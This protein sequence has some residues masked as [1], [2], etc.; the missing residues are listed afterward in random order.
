MR[1]VRICLVDNYSNVL[2]NFLNYLNFLKVENIKVGN[3]LPYLPYIRT[4]E[5]VLSNV[6]E[7][8]IIE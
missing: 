6:Y 3:P 4:V 7:K 5:H 2:S 8:P 1:R